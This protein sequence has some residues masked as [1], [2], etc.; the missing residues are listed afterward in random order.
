MLPTFP[1]FKKISLDDKTDY[2]RLVSEYPPFSDIAFP[3]L[4]IW[5][6]SDDQLQISSLNGNIVINYYLAFDDD[7]SGYSLVGKNSLDKSISEIFQELARQHKAI[8]LVHVPEFVIEAI[9]DKDKLVI[10]EETDY[11]EYI[12][13]SKS[14]AGLVGTAH[15][16]TRR[17]VK[18]FWDA[19]EGRNVE[20]KQL[21][22]SSPEIK[23][24]LYGAI[25]EWEKTKTTNNDPRNTER[26]AISNTIAHAEK[27]GIRHLGVYIDGVL[28]GIQLYHLSHDSNY[29]VLHHLKV[30]YSIP[31]IIDYLTHHIADK[32]VKDNVKFLNM[33]M[34]LGIEGL[35]R[36]K[37]ELRPVDF[38][39]KYTITPVKK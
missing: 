39:R 23:K 10:S 35:R 32:A 12:I 7:N 37:M 24:E 20:I 22:L 28:S 5:W 8:K 26:H 1:E 9:N 38:F 13:E 2:E 3:T 19:M 6:N 33:E 16:T 15:R 14:L 36:H 30:D 11:N 29:Y 21:E 27:L 4:H 31:Y 17:K 34:D 18:K 25:L